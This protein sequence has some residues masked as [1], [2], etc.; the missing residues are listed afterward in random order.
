MDN[1]IKDLRSQMLKT[2]EM[3]MF[4]NGLF[5]TSL[6]IVLPLTAF[7]T[8][9]SLVFEYMLGQQSTIGTNIVAAVVAVITLHL[10]LGLYIY[11]AYF[12][13]EKKNKA[14]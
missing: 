9:K 14:D 3:S 12:D 4:K 6:I 11:R 10:A 13:D 5:Y 7:F 1:E 2:D 8:T